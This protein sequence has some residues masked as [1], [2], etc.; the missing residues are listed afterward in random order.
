MTQKK[1]VLKY[2]ICQKYKDSPRTVPIIPSQLVTSDIGQSEK[3]QLLV[4][5][6]TSVWLTVG[7]VTGLPVGIVPMAVP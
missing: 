1:W 7:C 4:A 6:I 2:E 5:E 3:G